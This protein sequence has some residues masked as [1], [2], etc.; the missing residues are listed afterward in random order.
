MKSQKDFNQE[1]QAA[2]IPNSGRQHHGIGVLNRG[3]EFQGLYLSASSDQ[4]PPQNDR[5][6]ARD[7]RT[8][9]VESRTGSMEQTGCLERPQTEGSSGGK[10]IEIDMLKEF[11]SVQSN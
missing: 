8:T 2:I 4:R 1:V 3:L 7:V 11:F 6:S 10:E 5:Q 9:V